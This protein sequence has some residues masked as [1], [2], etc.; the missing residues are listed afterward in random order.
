VKG[1]DLPEGFLQ[2][3]SQI[4]G[5]RA[6]IVVDHLIEYGQITTEDLENYYLATAVIE[7]RIMVSGRG[8]IPWDGSRNIQY[9]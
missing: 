4:K 2:F 1:T 3:L 5:K 6:R 8:R 7:G 9:G